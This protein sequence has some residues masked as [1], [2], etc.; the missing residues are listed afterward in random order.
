MIVLPFHVLLIQTELKFISVG[1]VVINEDIMSHLKYIINS[2][3]V[4]QKSLCESEIIHSS[5]FVC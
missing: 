2:P 3:E 4:I 1:K 5:K